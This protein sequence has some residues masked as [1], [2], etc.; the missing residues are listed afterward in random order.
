MWRGVDPREAEERMSYGKVVTSS[1]SEASFL[2]RYGFNPVC[3]K[4]R[5]GVA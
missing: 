3:P 2:D 1:A 5:G 4:L